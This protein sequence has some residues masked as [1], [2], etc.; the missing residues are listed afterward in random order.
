MTT[1]YELLKRRR[2]RERQIPP[3]SVCVCVTVCVCVAENRVRRVRRVILWNPPPET[4]YI[5]ANT[6]THIQSHTQKHSHTH[7][8]LC[9]SSSL[10]ARS[11]HQV[12][13]FDLL[14]IRYQLSLWMFKDKSSF[15]HLILCLNY[16]VKLKEVWVMS[17]VIWLHAH[18]HTHTHTTVYDDDGYHWSLVCFRAS[19]EDDSSGRLSVRREK[20]EET[21]AET[22]KTRSTV[23]TVAHKHTHIYILQ[24][25]RFDF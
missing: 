3:L 14:I 9:S 22:V 18:T 25:R 15:I 13:Y 21:R 10:C 19:A 17:D 6:H 7:S 2:Q 11:S 8:S 20:E 5:T 4:Q 24:W 1:S 12:L 23:H 16:R